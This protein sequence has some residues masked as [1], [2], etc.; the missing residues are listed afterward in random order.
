MAGADSG[1]IRSID[2]LRAVAILLVFV[3]HYGLGWIVPGGFGVTLFFFISG[4]LI[5]ALMIAEENRNGRIA[6]GAFY[7]RRFLRLAPGLFFMIAIVSVLYFILHHDINTA[8]LL[9]AIFYMMNYFEIFN[10]NS[11]MPFWVLWSLAVEEHYYLIY[12][13]AFLL[14]WPYRERFLA[15]LLTLCLLV[16]IWRCVLV[17]EFHATDLW[18]YYATDTRINSIL[19]GA[20]L[21]VLMSVCEPAVLRRW[22]SG[23]FTLVAASVA[24]L[25]SL[26]FRNDVFRDAVRFS[27]QGIAL[28]PLFYSAV[29]STRL[30]VFRKLL[31]TPLSVWVGRLSYSL[32]LWHASVLYFCFAYFPHQNVWV[33]RLIGLMATLCIASFSYYY[34][35]MPFQRWRTR[36][37]KV[38]DA[39]LRDARAA[40]FLGS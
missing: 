15:G 9:A 16:L 37:R 1:H 24:L 31:E 14:G 23:N 40:P 11:S 22:L 28:V 35:E 18:T 33:Q 34:V 39:V 3:S 27:V 8:Q 38:S 13:L 32:Y 7:A 30:A 5:T 19:F 21:A 10:G 4:Y 36:F 25:F 6:I 26:V 17:V 12:P 2:G 20:I 29:F